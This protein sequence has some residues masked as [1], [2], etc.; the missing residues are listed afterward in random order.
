MIQ[1][2]FF[3]TAAVCVGLVFLLINELV[4]L[5]PIK[6]YIWERYSEKILLFSGVLFANLFCLFYGFIRW[7]RLQDTGDKLKHLEKQLRGS[8]TISEE[9]TSRILERK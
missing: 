9:L 1:A 6:G 4:F 7:T 3:A 8:E 5:A 2:S